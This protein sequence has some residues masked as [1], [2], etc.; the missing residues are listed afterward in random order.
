MIQKPV[1]MG[2]W[3][4]AASLRQRTCSCITSCVEI[5]G[6][7]SNHPGDSAP[8]QPRLGTLQLLAFPKTKITFERKEISDLQWDSGKYDR[9][10]DG[11]SNKGLCRMFWTVE[12]MLRELCEVPRCLLWR[13]LRCHC[14]VYCVS[15]ICIFFNKCLYISYYMAGYLLD[16]PCIVFQDIGL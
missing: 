7:T 2:N 5:F 12:E 6:E 1:A 9:A 14:P 15:C 11:D 13:R 3:W 16:R 4:L 10:A 8:L